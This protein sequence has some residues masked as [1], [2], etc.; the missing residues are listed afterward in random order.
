MSKYVCLL[1]E[2]LYEGSILECAVKLDRDRFN[3][4][5]E[6]YEREE[7]KKKL[8]EF[9]P[10]HVRSCGPVLRIHEIFEVEIWP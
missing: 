8:A 9:L 5:N 4:D 10:L 6:D 2:L 1:V 7:V 3:F